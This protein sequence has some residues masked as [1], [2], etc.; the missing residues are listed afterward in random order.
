VFNT[1]GSESYTKTRLTLG[2]GALL[3]E[4]RLELEKEEA[5]MTEEIGKLVQLI[6][7]L[8]AIK[9]KNGSLPPLHEDRLASSIRTR[10]KFSNEIK[11][12]NKRIKQIE[13]SFLDNVNLNIEV[14]KSVWPGVTI[15]IGEMRKKIENKYDRSRIS[16]GSD[17]EIS[18][19][20]ITGSI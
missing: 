10:F 4:E 6:D 19:A 3:A 2:N 11:I 14:R 1:V 17:G 16:I 9:K 12:I 7:G 13:E 18:I 8:N 20:P 15:R 5:K